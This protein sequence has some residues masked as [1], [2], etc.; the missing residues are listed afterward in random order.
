MTVAPQ[1]IATFGME[2]CTCNTLLPQMHLFLKLRERIWR[3]HGPNRFHIKKEVVR[4]LFKEISHAPSLWEVYGVKK[5]A[6]RGRKRMQ[7]FRNLITDT[8][9]TSVP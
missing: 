5:V 9:E 1:A 2:K 3:N 6:K 4:F 7:L 8:K